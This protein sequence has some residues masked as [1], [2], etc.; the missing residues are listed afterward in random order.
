MTRGLRVKSGVVMLGWM[1]GLGCAR[2]P[3]SEDTEYV[4]EWPVPSPEDDKEAE[5]VEPVRLLRQ[6]E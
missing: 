5:E 3:V 6:W 4:A 2:P 1:G